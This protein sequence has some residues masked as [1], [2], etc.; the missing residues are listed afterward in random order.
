MHYSKLKNSTKY[1]PRHF[2]EKTFTATANLSV[3]TFLPRN[4][5]L[6]DK[7]SKMTLSAPLHMSRIFP[8]GHRTITDIRLRVLLNSRTLS[9]WYV[10]SL[11]NCVRINDRCEVEVHLFMTKKYAK[12][13]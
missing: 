13:P 2:V 3:T 9:T 12:N 5:D 11:S 7:R 10:S 6:S 8:S 1:L 4:F